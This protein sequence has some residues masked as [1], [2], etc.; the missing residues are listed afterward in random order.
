[1]ARGGRAQESVRAID[2]ARPR[3]IAWPSPPALSFSVAREHVRRWLISDAAAGRLMP[4]LPI[5]FGTGIILYF[6]VDR[7]PNPWVAPPLTALL[8]LAAM[9]ARG[10]PM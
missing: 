1:M 4:W 5:A 6:T 10:R 2:V 7:E 9:V 3:G 8:A